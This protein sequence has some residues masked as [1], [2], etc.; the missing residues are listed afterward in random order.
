LLDNQKRKL[1]IISQ[2]THISKEILLDSTTYG[3]IFGQTWKN[4]DSKI[5]TLA[6]Q[7]GAKVS[8]EEHTS[9]SD[10]M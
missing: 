6:R 4:T 1:V 2:Q 5:K 10:Q 8:T 7:L 9:L 3:P